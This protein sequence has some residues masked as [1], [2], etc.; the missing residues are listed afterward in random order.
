MD[1]NK[2]VTKM[3]LGPDAR[4][5]RGILSRGNNIYK[6]GSFSSKNGNLQEAARNRL[7]QM[8]QRQLKWV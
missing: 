2:Y 6:N 4:S 7:K 3:S 8:T 1:T 5:Y